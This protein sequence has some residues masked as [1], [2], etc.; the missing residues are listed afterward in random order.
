MTKA[1]WIAGSVLAVILLLILV[2]S[3]APAS[4]QTPEPPQR[5]RIVDRSC[6][7]YS[8][9]LTVWSDSK[10]GTCF[11]QATR[12]TYHRYGGGLVLVPKELCQ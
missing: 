6:N 1:T 5:F 7:D 10:T 4:G 12:D 9:C 8:G 3:C 11:V 2:T